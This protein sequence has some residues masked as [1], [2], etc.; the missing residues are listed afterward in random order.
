MAYAP[1]KDEIA[2]RIAACHESIRTLHD[3]WRR[4]AG[5]RSMPSRA[6]IDPSE[7]KPFLSSIILVDVVPDARR[8]VYRLTG[9]SEVAERGYDPTGKT[10]AESHYGGSAEETLS[11]YQYPVDHRAPY[12]WRDPFPGPDGRIETEDI[13]YLPLSEDDDTVN[14]ILVY[15]Y[16]YTFRPRTEATSL[17]R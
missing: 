16:N 3:Y 4:K 8:F 2:A 11:Y 10:V 15:T 6:D 1:T 14:M 7:I 5:K 17:L 12:C 9:T 13:I